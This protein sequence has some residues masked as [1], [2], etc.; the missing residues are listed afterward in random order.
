MPFG[1]RDWHEIKAFRLHPGE[2]G[3]RAVMVWGGGPGGGGKTIKGASETDES[4]YQA[5]FALLGLLTV[6]AVQ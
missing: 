5:Y 4:G 2:G 3:G 1:K 6:P